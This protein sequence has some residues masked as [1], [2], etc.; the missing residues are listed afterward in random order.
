METFDMVKIS[1]LVRK[2]ELNVVITYF[3]DGEPVRFIEGYHSTHTP[4]KNP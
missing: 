3:C 1:S 4:I 2:K